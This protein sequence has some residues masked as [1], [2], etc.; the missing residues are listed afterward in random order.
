MLVKNLIR[1]N[2]GQNFIQVEMDLYK[3][4]YGQKYWQEIKFGRLAV[5]EAN[6]QIKIRQYIV[7]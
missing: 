4:P 3:L 1:E 2:A 7:H 6:C 5:L